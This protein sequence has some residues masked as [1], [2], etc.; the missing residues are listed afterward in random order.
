MP[1]ALRK[2][3]D[4]AACAAAPSASVPSRPGRQYA[5]TAWVNLR[6]HVVGRGGR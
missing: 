4:I 3:P 6:S 2:R 5:T 1:P